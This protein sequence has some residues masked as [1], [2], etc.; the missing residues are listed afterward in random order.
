MPTARNALI[1]GSTGNSATPTATA[2]IDRPNE[3][4]AWAK[5]AG[6]GPD[7]GVGDDMIEGSRRG[8]FAVLSTAT[9]SELATTV[10]AEHRADLVRGRA[11]AAAG[12]RHRQRR[13]AGGAELAA[14]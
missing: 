12:H 1:H 7:A 4:A 9:Q 14:V 2:S 13:A 8:P 11:A 10:R 6:V 5:N 3:I